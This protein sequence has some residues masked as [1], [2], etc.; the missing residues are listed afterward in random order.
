[1]VNQMSGETVRNVKKKPLLLRIKQYR[2]VYLM[3]IPVLAYY[4]IF[5]YF[6]MYGIV[7]SFKEFYPSEGILGSPWASPFYKNF[8]W[9]FRQ[10]YF[11][12]AL[13]NTLIISVLKLIFCFPVPIILALFFSEINIR[14]GK[15][16]IQTILYIPYFFSWAVVAGLVF[17][18]LATNSGI[19]NKVI[20]SLGGTKTSFMTES[21]YFY[22]ILIISENWKNAGWGMVIYIAAITNVNPRLYEAAK[23]D[24]CSRVRM[25]F[26]ITIPTILPIIVVMF[27]MAI[28]NILNAGFDPVFNLYNPAV[29]DVADI[30]DTYIYRLGITNGEYEKAAALGLF[31]ASINVVLLVLGNAAVKKIT[32]NGIYE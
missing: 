15:R 6:P 7:I 26:S 17:S 8:Q 11:V 16:G 12:R 20:V 22:T 2:A 29:Y 31:K 9:L 19:L 14:K 27:I 28:G 32:G 21:K 13:K 3:L 10:D 5:C 18:L 30:L 23:I 25:M 24:G 1:M 4:I